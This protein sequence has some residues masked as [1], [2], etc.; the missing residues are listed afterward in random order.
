MNIADATS[1]TFI[2]EVVSSPLVAWNGRKWRKRRS[3]KIR[4]FLSPFLY[5]RTFI[6]LFFSTFKESEVSSSPASAA[7][8][9][10]Q[11]V[12]VSSEFALFTAGAREGGRC[13]RGGGKVE[14]EEE[15]S[16]LLDFLPLFPSYPLPSFL[17]FSPL[18][19]NFPFILPSSSLPSRQKSPADSPSPP[20]LPPTHRPCNLC[21]LHESGSPSA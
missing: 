9:T 3:N 5:T 14:V 10:W 6:Q 19:S 1:I 7:S 21:Y 13:R 11:I 4:T 2:T 15:Q 16:R 12:E 17:S 8:G 20:P 18:F